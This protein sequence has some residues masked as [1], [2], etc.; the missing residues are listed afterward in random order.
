MASAARK[1]SSLLPSPTKV[2]SWEGKVSND[3]IIRGEL[4]AN[5][6]T[7]A[8]AILRRRGIHVAKIKK[9]TPSRKKISAKDIALLTRQLATMMKAGVPLLQAFHIL[10]QGNDHPPI[11]TL[12]QDIRADVETGTSLHQAFRKFPLHFD[13]LFCN[14]VAAGEHAGMLDV[15]LERLA[16]HL[17][18]T[19][20]I[21][22]KIR[23]AMLYPLS[24]LLA[25]GAMTTIIMIWVVPTFKEIFTSFGAALPLPTL[26]VIA[27]SD[28]LI[29]HWPVILGLLIASIY[30][31][32]QGW[33]RSQ[34]MRHAADRILLRLPV[35]GMLLRKA[36]ITRWA[37]TF[38]TMFTAGVPLV[39]ALDS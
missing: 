22:K 38:A 26:A 11:V 29:M 9:K 33:Q 35:F 1:A 4:H 13:P 36:V 31:C 19:L 17:E 6:A 3:K 12:M 37:R 15:L 20:A 39:E 16:T 30:L 5:D 8:R 14:L 2:F 7:T 24:I 34:R 23:S 25:A 18:K 27:L 32:R 28:F 21:K 10:A